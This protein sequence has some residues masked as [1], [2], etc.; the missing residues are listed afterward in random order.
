MNLR[1]PGGGKLA[2]G[3]IG[4]LTGLAV[5]GMPAYANVP[6]T[7]TWVDAEPTAPASGT[8]EPPPT[9][10]TPAPTESA[11]STPP[12]TSP[13]DEPK[14][15]ADLSVSAPGSKVTVGSDGKWISIRVDHNEGDTAEDVQV[16]LRTSDLSESVEVELPGEDQDCHT[17]GDETICDYPDLDPLDTDSVVAFK[18]TPTDEAKLGPVGTVHAS[19]T[20]ST[21]DP[22]PEN[23]Q[24]HLAIE[25]VDSGP[26]LTAWAY[27][28]GPVQPGEQR[29]LSYG[30]AN[31]GDQPISGYAVTIDLPRYATL[32]ERYEDCTYA[33]GGAKASCSLPGEV[34]RP[35][36]AVDLEGTFAIAVS[37][38]APGPMVLGR[39]VFEV[40]PLDSAAAVSKANGS[41]AATAGSAEPRGR[42]AGDAVEADNT[43][44]FAVKTKQNTGDLAIKA[45]RVT[46]SAGEKVKVTFTV[47]NHGPADMS[48]FRFTVKA[49]TGADISGEPSDD[50]LDCNDGG[51][52]DAR[53]A[54]C[55]FSG[56]VP[57]AGQARTF[58]MTFKIQAEQVDDDGWA[59]VVGNGAEDSNLKN[60]TAT[61]AIVPPGSG[62]GGGSDLPVT[63]VAF[64][65]IM[66]LGLA[67]VA[68][69]GG[70]LLAARRRRA[71]GAVTVGGAAN[72][73]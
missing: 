69:G 73:A 4:V 24:A 58:T 28:V 5:V 10:T 39:G 41:F 49:P 12:S 54:D 25:L 65:A 62:G 32:V 51:N 61:L 8:P 67:A 11:P 36:E 17:N 30:F 48:G 7:K 38:R 57:G 26:D 68:A 71:A 3:V 66:G 18:V 22:T 42:D 72:S 47:V 35:G 6:T 21:E 64:T 14:P 33:D 59:K 2:A 15:W 45:A 53:E 37:K 9:A 19:V 16:T 13:T 1:K 70:L 50:A 34:V 27:A 55:N 23:N 43:I 46:G 29:T 20:S 63:G 52:L 56:T 40:S 60:N 44:T 31:Q